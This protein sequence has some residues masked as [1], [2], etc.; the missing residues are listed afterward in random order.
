M[1]CSLCQKEGDLAP[2]KNT[3]SSSFSDWQ[4][5]TGTNGFCD[6]CQ[7][8][9]NG[10]H[11]FYNLYI[12]SDPENFGICSRKELFEHIKSKDPGIYQITFG[13]KKHC[14]FFY[15]YN[16]FSSD[17][18]SIATDKGKVNLSYERFL[19]AVL[20]V[21]SL[22]GAGFSKSDIRHGESQKVKKIEKFGIDEYFKKM[23]G[24]PERGT[25][26]MEIYLFFGGEK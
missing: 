21:D 20:E 26:V 3:V 14:I 12:K 8:L 25:L 22:L 5:L 17:A 23:M 6:N 24:F 7:K 10:K 19:S 16:D 13:K 2:I 18:F 1:K 11:R 15:Q 9:F 4:Y